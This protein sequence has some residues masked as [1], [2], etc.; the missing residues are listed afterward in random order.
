MCVQGG[1]TVPLT[2]TGTKVKSEMQRQYGSEKG[3]H[4]FYASMNKGRPGSKS[5][6][7]K[8]SKDLRKR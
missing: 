3:E 8:A 6:H 5:W 4:V 1:V 7:R 2:K